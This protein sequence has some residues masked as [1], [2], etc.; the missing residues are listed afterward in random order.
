MDLLDTTTFSISVGILAVVLSSVAAGA[1]WLS[2][3]HS[4]VSNT[5]TDIADLQT[6]TKEIVNELK[7]VNKNLVALQSV[8]KR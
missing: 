4:R 3:I 1:W 7:D 2:S 6:S 8:V 5:E